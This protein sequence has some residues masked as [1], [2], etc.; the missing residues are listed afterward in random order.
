MNKKVSKIK[1]LFSRNSYSL[2]EEKIPKNRI[3][4]EN[5]EGTVN[6]GDQLPKVICEYMLNR[7]HLTAD[8]PV[9]KSVHLLTVGSVI[10]IGLFDAVI[11]GS[12]IHLINTAFAARKQKKIRNLDIRAVR[13]PVTKEILRVIGYDCSKVAMGDP[14]IL[15]PL[16]YQ[17][18]H[19]EKKYKFSV[20]EHFKK[21]QSAESVSCHKI[22]VKTKDYRNFIDELAASELVISS[23]LHGIILAEA[24]GVPAIFVNPDHLMDHQL[25]KYYDWYYSTGRDNVV[26]AH[27]VEE[28]LTMTPMP[29][30]HLEELQESL[31]R[32][33]PYDLWKK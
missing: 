12:G 18:E 11:W 8:Q 14:A 19:I 33:F 10:G 3:I 9:S 17:P 2:N 25:M 23:S 13:G 6:I 15:M 5:W 31:I 26:I 4:I 22:S 1:K 32:A 28:A 7:E 20:V 24:Y 27:S 29:L 21:K 30:P 16:I